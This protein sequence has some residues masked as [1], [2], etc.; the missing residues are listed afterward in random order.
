MTSFTGEC[1]ET[2][3]T[4]GFDLCLF[5]NSTYW[6]CSTNTR[7]RSLEIR[8]TFYFEYF[9]IL[10]P[11]MAHLKVWRIR[12][13]CYLLLFIDDILQFFYVVCHIRWC[14]RAHVLTYYDIP[15]PLSTP[16]SKRRCFILSYNIRSSAE[17]SALVQWACPNLR[18]RPNVI[19]WYS[20][21]LPVTTTAH[22]NHKG[23]GQTPP[24]S[25]TKM[26]SSFVLKQFK[27]ADSN[28]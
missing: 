18:L 14:V 16:T 12:P 9:K 11:K 15:W 25:I 7:T 1:T 10:S 22:R 24:T 27:D 19:I 4:F 5:H 13:T 26:L 20:V 6:T 3:Q 21:H 23:R 17:R 28:I 8:C 2:A